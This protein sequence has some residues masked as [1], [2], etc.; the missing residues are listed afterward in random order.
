MGF[1]SQ[2]YS[3]ERPDNTNQ[4]VHMSIW[5]RNF[6]RTPLVLLALAEAGILFVSVYAA[7]VFAV[8]GIELFEDTT[9]PIAPKAAILSVVMIVSLIAMGLYQFHQRVY[10]HEVIVRIL[11]GVAIGSA[12]LAA[13]YYVFP[14]LNLQP[15]IAATAV[16][17]SLGFLL[18]LRYFF[19]RSVDENIFRRRT[20]IYG[21]GDK[22]GA[23]FDLKRRADRRG[24]L[25]VGTIPAPGDTH[26]NETCSRLEKHKTLSQVALETDADEIVIAMDDRRQNLPIREL[27]DAKLRGVDV[28]D[29]IE[30]LERETG[31]IEI[32]LVNPAY[33]IFSQGFRHG[34]VARAMKRMFDVVVAVLSL[35]AGAPIMLVAAIAIKLEDGMDAP[36]IYRQTRVGKNG[37]PF[38]VLKFRSMRVDAEKDGKAVWAQKDDPRITRV[39]AC[40]RKMRIDELPQIFNV[41]GGSMSIVGPRPE[42][43]EF[44][45]QLLQEIPYYAERHSVKPG[46]TGW[47]QLRFT[48]GASKE[49]TSE[50]LRYDLYYVKNHSLVLD[51]MII[52]QTA[53]VILWGKGAR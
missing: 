22:A 3:S 31:K 46:V 44:V 34:R 27:L 29:L 8:G 9:G 26:C 49:E 52:L 13:A 1:M 24:F 48:Y 10:Y 6:A 11:V 36:V 23:I 41:L 19:I 33:L 51:L 28:I 18:L 25:I 38:N 20:L 53:E 43:P 21:A 7:V 40:L 47:A 12:F 17:S 2:R 4:E 45:E 35:I 39:G 37:N 5:S 32:D 14:S 30:F 42:R 50:K 15:R 16:V